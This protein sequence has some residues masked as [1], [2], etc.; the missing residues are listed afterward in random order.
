MAVTTSIPRKY[1]PALCYIA[2][3]LIFEQNEIYDQKKIMFDEADKRLLEAFSSD[4]AVM[5]T[6]TIE[7]AGYL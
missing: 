2:A 1:I 4:N 3:A 7:R 6:K 5:N